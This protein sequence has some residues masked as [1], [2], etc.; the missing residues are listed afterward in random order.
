MRGLIL[1]LGIAAFL[2]GGCSRHYG[3]TTLYQISGRQKPIVAVLP[4]IVPS[5]ENNT[6]WDLSREFTDE[7]RKR[8]YDSKKIYL[9][10]EGATLEIAH[11]LSTPN[12]Q[13]IAPSIAKSLGDAEFV[14]VTEIIHHDQ[15]SPV[16]PRPEAEAIVSLDVR[17][18]VVDVRGETPQIILQELLN[19][20]FMV[21]KAYARDYTKAS[22][23]TE[24][25][26]HTPMGMAH[27][28]LLGEIVSRIEAYIEAAL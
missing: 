4:V 16:S 1:S 13:A 26:N 12:P 24:I 11:L 19:Q 15:I 28:R 20:N 23:G 6:T 14:V 5:S 25:F 18:R 22:W 10:R 2:C 9:L 7:I 21:G 8:V 3:D 27:N 17:L